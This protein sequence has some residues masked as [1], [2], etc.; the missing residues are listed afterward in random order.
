MVLPEIPRH[1][2]GGGGGQDHQRIEHQQAHPVDGQGHHHG[3]AD[4]EAGLGGL[5]LQAAG[6]G[7]IIEKPGVSG[8]SGSAGTT[9]VSGVVTSFSGASSCSGFT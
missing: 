4:G 5:D 3:D 2:P 7:S 1:I 9:G 6:G 8:S